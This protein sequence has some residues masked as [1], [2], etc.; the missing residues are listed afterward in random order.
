MT[1]CRYRSV[2]P[3]S[4][5]AAFLLAWT[6]ACAGGMSA[7]PASQAEI[8]AEVFLVGDA[9][10]MDAAAT[11]AALTRTVN[12]ATVSKDRIRVLF[13][14]DNIYPRG[15]PD[16]SDLV[17]R[18]E[19]E[20]ILDL[21]L[22]V[23]ENAGVR[24]HFVPGNHDW[25]QTISGG[26]PLVLRQQRYIADHSDGLATLLPGNGCPGPAV[27]EVGQTVRILLLD[28]EVW[29]RRESFGPPT[30]CPATTRDAVVNS[31]H[32]VLARNDRY[33]LVAAHHPIES[34]GPH[35]GFVPRGASQSDEPVSED[36]SSAPYTA[37]KHDLATAFSGA[38][39]LVYAAGHEHTLQVLNGASGATLLVSGSAHEVTSVRQLAN[40][41]YARALQGFMRL[42]FFADASVHLTVYEVTSNGRTRVGFERSIASA[43]PGAFQARPAGGAQ[44]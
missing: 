10:A 34:G 36:L 13:L 5:A 30:N 3:A 11:L 28:T 31:L 22:A 2:G 35:G 12:D 40:A 33:A 14:G 21:Q 44:P 15:M 39:P 23:L 43:R 19:T 26:L 16:S 6:S 41:P 20:Q 18:R 25:S 7:A 27:I 37:L 17:L 4:L 42:T 29:L 8:D 1:R 24:G 32:T 9:G 38:A